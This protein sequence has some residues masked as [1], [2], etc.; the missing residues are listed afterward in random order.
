MGCRQEIG[1]ILHALALLGLERVRSIVM[2][3]ALRNIIGTGLQEPVLL[4]CWRHSIACALLGEQ[5]A[6]ACWMDKD[7]AYTAGLLHDSGRLGLLMAY[8]EE[9]ARVLDTADQLGRDTRICEREAFGVDHCEAGRDLAREWRLPA[10][11]EEIALH[12]H[13]PPQAVGFNTLTLI[14]LACRLADLLGFQVA[15]PA[16]VTSI[17]EIRYRLPE[18]ARGEFKSGNALVLSV[19]AKINSLECSLT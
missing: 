11:L 6:S 16:P 4:R 15:G 17:D 19:A 10:E 14:Q 1:S 5:I 7:K 9:Y 8:P 3:V 13:D 18:C 2:T 12:H